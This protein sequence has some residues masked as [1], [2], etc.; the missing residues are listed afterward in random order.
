MMWGGGGGVIGVLGEGV[1]RPSEAKVDRDFFSQKFEY[2]NR[3]LE[4]LKTIFREWNVVKIHGEEL[5]FKK[6][7]NTPRSLR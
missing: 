5:L 7:F 6:K 4:H 3:I 1:K 2:Q